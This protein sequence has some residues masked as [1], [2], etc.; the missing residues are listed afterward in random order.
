MVSKERIRRPRRG[1]RRRRRGGAGRAATVRR[2]A[3]ERAS[4]VGTAGKRVILMERARGGS[5][6][7][8]VLDSRGRDERSA[9]VDQ[10]AGSLVRKFHSNAHAVVPLLKTI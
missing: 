6:R 8:S 1:R 2:A 4:R 10:C 5:D 3:A 9:R 7:E